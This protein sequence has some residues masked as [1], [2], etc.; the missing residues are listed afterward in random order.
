MT[1]RILTRDQLD[2]WGL[3]YDLIEEDEAADHPEA[4]VELHREQTD[5][6]RWASTHTLVFRAPDDGKTYRVTYQEPLTEHQECD[7]WFDDREVN[8]F[9][10]K[11]RAQIVTR[12]TRV[13]D[14]PPTGDIE[15]Y[16]FTD[17][18]G[19]LLHIGVPHS[20]VNGGPAIS[21][22]TVV[23]PVHVPIERIPEL[24]NALRRLVA[25]Q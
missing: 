15:P 16:Q 22:H 12:W 24:I 21:F 20:P 25:S 14:Q 13:T 23:D 4:A 7:P 8:A 6:R 17:N 10:V 1:T 11:Q 3:P 18:D 2:D 9:E 5:T 19:D